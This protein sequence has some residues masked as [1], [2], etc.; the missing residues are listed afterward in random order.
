MSASV[1]VT[2]GQAFITTGTCI[3]FDCISCIKA[4]IAFSLPGSISPK[5]PPS[6]HV[7]SAMF[8]PIVVAMSTTGYADAVETAVHL[9]E[10]SCNPIME[11]AIAKF[12]LLLYMQTNGASAV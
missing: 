1:F 5:L 7:A 8:S 10:N 6:V 4:A 3:L 12:I 9:P 2:S 11:S